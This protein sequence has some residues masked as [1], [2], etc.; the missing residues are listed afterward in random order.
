MGIRGRCRLGKGQMETA[1][2][3]TE[4]GVARLRKTAAQLRALAQ[5]HAE[6]ENHAITVKLNQVV[7]EIEAEADALERFGDPARPQRRPPPSSALSAWDHR[8]SRY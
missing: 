6:A 2:L 5:R 8:S 7:A 4:D 1:T 3:A